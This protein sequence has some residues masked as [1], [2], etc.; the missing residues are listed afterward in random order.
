MVGPAPARMAA[1]ELRD[2]GSRALPAWSG[3]APEVSLR[4]RDAAAP[5]DARS[6]DRRAASKAAAL[7]AAAASG[8][9]SAAVERVAGA[10][11]A[12]ASVV[13]RFLAQAERLRLRAEAA[14]W[15]R[16]GS[17]LAVAARSTPLEWAWLW[18]Q[19]VV[20]AR[21]RL[22][23]DPVSAHWKWG[24]ALGAGEPAMERR[25]L[26]P[27]RQAHA[28]LRGADRCLSADESA[29]PP[30]A[31]ESA[32]TEERGSPPA[33]REPARESLRPTLAEV[34]PDALA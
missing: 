27:E 2:E 28:D 22:P 34:R 1:S 13:Q 31:D 32:Q 18:A 6:A 15:D 9:G 3:A 14:A 4:D 8:H 5:P 24:A 7:A 19:S 29:S 17:A 23:A 11:S 20:L 16:K 21:S 12:S 30:A 26:A 33:F 10:A 25:T